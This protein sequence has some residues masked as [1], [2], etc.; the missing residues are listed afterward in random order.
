[1]VETLLII[2][3]L[4]AVAFA[5]L[6][7]CIVVLDDLICTEAAFSAVRSAVIA[8]DADCA[9]RAENTARLL[10]FP[11]AVS[12]NNMAY[13]ATR[14]WTKTVEGRDI[15]DHGRIPLRA[16]NANIEYRVF[17]SMASLL[18]PSGIT[19]TGPADLHHVARARMIKSP[20]E[21]YYF[22]A[23]PHARRFS[24]DSADE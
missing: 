12:L 9:S 4:T 16:F 20:D 19:H 3:T 21:A 2:V 15:R 14:V 1:M 5:A 11:H 23:Y 13:D 24:Q 8:P 18:R 6:Q 7:L 22:R 17:I 10:L